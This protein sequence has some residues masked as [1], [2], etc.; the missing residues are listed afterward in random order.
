VSKGDRIAD[1]GAIREF[2]QQ[3]GARVRLLETDL[4]HAVVH[5]DE[6]EAALGPAFAFLDERFPRGAEKIPSL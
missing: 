6:A 1:A 2:C 5:D 3:A 4:G